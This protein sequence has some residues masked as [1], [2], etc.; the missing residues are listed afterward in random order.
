MSTQS[1]RSRV[2]FLISGSANQEN[3]R[4]Q[5]NVGTIWKLLEAR[6]VSS[7]NILRFANP[8][9]VRGPLYHLPDFKVPVNISTDPRPL[10]DFFG[11][12]NTSSDFRGCLMS[13]SPCDSFF[14][15]YTNHGVLDSLKFPVGQL[16]YEEFATIIKDLQVN[17]RFKFLLIVIESC[18]SAALLPFLKKIPNVAAVASSSAFGSCYATDLYSGN[19]L[20]DYF[21]RRFAEALNLEKDF[22]LSELTTF[23]FQGQTSTQGFGLKYLIPQNMKD[24]LLSIFVDY[25]MDQFLIF[26]LMTIGLMSKVIHMKNQILFSSKKKKERRAQCNRKWNVSIL[27]KK[28]LKMSLALLLEI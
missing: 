11:K 27:L 3:I 10:K 24:L 23:L 12:L 22:T 4:H 20:S 21:T 17:H 25:L 28:Q 2:A 19:I 5:G 15:Y 7:D 26:G 9:I 1:S 16:P 8:D 6:G 14:L 13:I 18:G